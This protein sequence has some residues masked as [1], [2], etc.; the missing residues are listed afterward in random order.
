MVRT[1]SSVTIAVHDPSTV[2]R[3][4]AELL[5]LPQPAETLLTLDEGRQ[6]LRFVA[7]EAG[8]VGAVAATFAL[9]VP[10]IRSATV[11]GVALDVV[12]YEEHA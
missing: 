11:A 9:P 10:T 6:E 1:E 12:P 7:A 4:W 3:R 5:D 2:A 8:L